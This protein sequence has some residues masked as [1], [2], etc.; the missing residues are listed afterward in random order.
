[1]EL[2]PFSQTNVVLQKPTSPR[3]AIRT[4]VHV[5]TVNSNE[6]NSRTNMQSTDL[7]YLFN[8]LLRILDL[9]MRQN[10]FD[11][12]KD[13][14]DYTVQQIPKRL[15]SFLLWQISLLFT[16]CLMYETDLYGNDIGQSDLDLIPCQESCSTDVNCNFWSYDTIN[17]ICYRKS[18]DSGK[19]VRR[20]FISGSKDCSPQRKA[21]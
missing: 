18:S 19:E 9:V 4:C 13:P 20:G 11:N 17:R 12:S 7:Q 10:T 6:R 21:R 5:R 14:D 2:M 1:M 16:E 15:S 8:S 3:L